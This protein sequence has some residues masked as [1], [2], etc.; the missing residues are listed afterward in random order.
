MTFRGGFFVDAAER[1]APDAT[2][3]CARKE[4]IVVE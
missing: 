4:Y 3:K 2:I 1:H